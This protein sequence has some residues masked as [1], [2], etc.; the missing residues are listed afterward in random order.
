MQKGVLLEANVHEGGFEAVLE[1]AHLAFEDAADEALLGGALDV[2]FLQLA[3]LGDGHAG[4]ERFGVNDDFLVDFLFWADQPLHFAHQVGGGDFDGFNDALGLLGN[5]DRGEVFF[6]LHFS[7]GLQIGFTEPAGGFALG[8]GRGVFGH[9]GG[10]VFRA[11]DFV[12]VALFEQAF[13]AALFANDLGAGL[14]GLAISL[15][16]GLSETPLGTEAHSAAAPR[17]F[18]VTHNQY[19]FRWMYMFCIK[20]SAIN[21]TST[22]DPP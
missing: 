19:P 17:E 22:E 3:V 5:H 12:V 16:R 14:D 2:E 13:V 4:F 15:L 21:E 6:L 7:R 8:R 20:P 1:I 11:F 18:L 10:D 9:A